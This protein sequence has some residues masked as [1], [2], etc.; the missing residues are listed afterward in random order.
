[1]DQTGARREVR[2][3]MRRL[4]PRPAPGMIQQEGTAQPFPSPFSSFFTLFL[5]H[6]PL[7][8][9]SDELQEALHGC[10]A[11]PTRLFIWLLLERTQSDEGQTCRAA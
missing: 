11:A 4:Q 9:L 6:V 5:S 1:M 10:L 2:G 7:Q 3:P 8:S